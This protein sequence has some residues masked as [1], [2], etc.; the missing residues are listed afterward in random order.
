MYLLQIFF[1][2]CGLS[3]HSLDTAFC[4]SEAFNFNEAQLIDYFFM[5]HVFG[6]MSK[7]SLPYQGHLG[8]LLCYC[9]GVLWY[10]V[11]HLGL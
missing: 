3:S 10:C 5:D 6:V 2:I 7:K 4:R 1:P 8:F 9:L 11:L